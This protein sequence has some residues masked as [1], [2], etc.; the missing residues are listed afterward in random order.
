MLTSFR[1]W[2]LYL[3]RPYAIKLE[4]VTVRA[5]LYGF[6]VPSFELLM[7]DGWVNLLTIVGQISDTL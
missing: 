1:V 4:D 5:P 6:D 3:G 7:S 2:S